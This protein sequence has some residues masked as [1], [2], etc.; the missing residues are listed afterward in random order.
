MRSQGEPRKAV[1]HKF[2]LAGKAGYTA[3][4]DL[5]GAKHNE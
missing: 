1:F 5:K 3:G 4:R 2:R